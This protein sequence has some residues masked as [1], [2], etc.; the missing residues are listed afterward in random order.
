MTS[1]TL[2]LFGK[3]A[4]AAPFALILSGCNQAA[5]DGAAL[6]GDAIAEVAAPEGGAWE[7][8]VEVTEYDGYRLGNPDAPIKLVEYASLTCPACAQFAAT[9][10]APLKADYVS[11]GR[12]S[13]ELRNLIRGPDDLALARLVRCGPAENFHPLSEQVWA[14]LNELV[15]P[16]YANQEAAQQALSLPEGERFAAL[17]DMAGMYDFFAARGVSENDARQC[18]ADFASLEKIATNSDSQADEFGVRG[19]P[20]FFVN[21]TPIEANGW[22][23]VED[24]LQRAGAR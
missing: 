3:L 1:K 12:V 2:S 9:G 17:A 18:L 5:A 16:I 6:E 11:T 13:Y 19:T 10:V 4:L 8:Q 21:G 24:A 22:D 7:T 23:A 15:S 20:T 14:N